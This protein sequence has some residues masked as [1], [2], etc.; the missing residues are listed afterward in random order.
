MPRESGKLHRETHLEIQKKKKSVSII[1]LEKLSNL[2]YDVAVLGRR[3]VYMS[4]EILREP[5]RG[6]SSAL[7]LVLPVRHMPYH[8]LTLTNHNTYVCKQYE[9]SMFR[10]QRIYCY[11]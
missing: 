2:F 5:M 4:F 11:L 3:C 7:H 10:R 6:F 1:L 9:K 8:G